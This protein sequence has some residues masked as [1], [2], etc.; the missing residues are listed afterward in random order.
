MS[1]LETLSSVH[2]RAVLRDIYRE[3]RFERQLSSIATL[4]LCWQICTR[5][6]ELVRLT[7]RDVVVLHPL[8]VWNGTSLWMQEIVNRYYY[9]AI[10]AFVYLGAALLLVAVGLNRTRVVESPVIVV[11]GV[12]LEAILL[13][14]LFTVMFFTP[15]EDPDVRSD[16][17][18]GDGAMTDELLR[19]LGEIGRDYAA[20]AVQLETIGSS[21][22][23]VVDR[24]DTLIRAVRDSVETAVSAVAPNPALMETM[25]ST[26]NALASLNE[27]VAAL[28]QRLRS[29]ERQEVERLVRV[30]LERILSR[31]II[32]RD[33]TAHPTP[34]TR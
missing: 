31:T 8:G 17:E 19:E 11:I 25:Q 26:T 27:S 18:R 28:D 5:E 7:K 33:A 15:A 9:A 10:N 32:E 4:R 12:L 16:S 3:L 34:P 2:G 30:E 1:Q 29:A 21:L 24:Q 22:Q 14:A 23:D 13:V 20:M 6:R